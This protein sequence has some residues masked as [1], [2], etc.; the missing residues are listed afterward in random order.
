MRRLWDYV[1]ARLP[2]APRAEVD[3]HLTACTACPTHVAFAGA[4]RQGLAAVAR[5]AR[6]DAREAA[7][8]ARVRVALSAAA[9][10]APA[11]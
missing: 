11:G 5:E 2:D 10:G 6:A 9:R 8:R 3:A 4:T 7:L 1:D